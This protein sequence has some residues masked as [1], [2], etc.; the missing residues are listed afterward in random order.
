MFEYFR[1]NLNW[2]TT[3]TRV[4]LPIFFA[5]M[6][7]VLYWFTAQSIKIK[8]FFFAKNTYDKASIKH[9][10]FTKVF[11][12]FSMGVAPTILCLFF[13]PELSIADYG[14]TIIPKTSMF[15][16]IWI[17]GLSFVVVPLAYF[18]AKKPKNLLNY[19]QI[20]AKFWTKK[21]LFIN[22]LGWFLYLFG[23][24]FLFRGTLLIPLE[25]A[26]GVWPAIAINVAL[27]SATHIP[28]GLDETLGAVPL[29]I[30][31]CLLTLASGTIWIAFIVHLAMAWTNSITAL[32]YNPKI[33]FK[34]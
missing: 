16:V 27:Y 17:V 14:L 4:F 26:L 10:F 32:K 2:S 22:L 20:R 21:T 8:A 34:Q 6:F 3:D 15:T 33:H 24:E 9:V 31:L 28:K 5:V 7:F 19:P 13:I 29:G 11:G 25:E 18:S 23:Y 1:V 12:F 30:V